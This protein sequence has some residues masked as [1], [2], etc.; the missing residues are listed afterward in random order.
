MKIL[1]VGNKYD[2]MNPKRGFS[3][4]HYNLY[5]TLKTMN[6]GENEVIYFAVDELIQK[7]SKEEINKNLL[8]ITYKEKPNFIWFF[9]GNIIKKETVKELTEKSGAITIIWMS[10][11]H[12]AFER[13]SKYWAHL[14]HWVAT[15]DSKAPE[16]YKKIGYNN[17]IK[18]QWAYNPLVYKKLDF[19]KIYDVIFIG[20][21]HSN[22]KVMIDKLI[23][24]GINVQCWGFGWKNGRISQD[25]MVK[26][27]CQ[28][29][30][31][32][33]FSKSSGIL[34]KELANLFLNRRMY[35]R[36]IMVN[37]PREFIDNLKSFLATMKTN[38][39]KGK[40]FEV[41]GCGSF[42]LTEHADN[43]EN[44]YK[45]GEEVV[46]FSGMK[47]LEEKIKYYLNNGEERER[48]ASAGYERTLREH[49]FEKRLN[50][51]FETIG[52]VK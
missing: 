30:I 14:F 17:V 49:T 32:L 52:L 21:P 43:L 29:K 1:Y 7:E 15:T 18:T 37:T 31:C 27:I 41:P 28:S 25:D 33:N 36:K 6:G 9:G 24:K 45:I 10:D 46:C 44:Y 5:N 47:D 48:I 2:Y 39:I 23:K 4:E 8:R 42:L 20:H 50:K 40:N 13:G 38:Q 19:P 12:W 22:R 34:W 3:F 51:I 26:K 16:K 11:D 35:D